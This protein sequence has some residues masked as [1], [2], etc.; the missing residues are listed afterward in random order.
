MFQPIGFYVIESK[1]WWDKTGESEDQTSTLR[2]QEFLKVESVQLEGTSKKGCCF[3]RLHSFHQ[4]NICDDR[5]VRTCKDDI[6]NLKIDLKC[7]YR[8]LI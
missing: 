5:L 6:I 2:S 4:Q 8:L 3:I 1:H 7:C